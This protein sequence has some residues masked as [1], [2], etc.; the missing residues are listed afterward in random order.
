MQLV[1]QPCTLLHLEGENSENCAPLVNPNIQTRGHRWRTLATVSTPT[2]C[3][4][5]A[6]QWS[7]SQQAQ[8]LWNSDEII[9]TVNR[10]SWK[11]IWRLYMAAASK[12]MKS[13][14]DTPKPEQ[15]CLCRREHSLLRPGK[16]QC[17]LLHETCGQMLTAWNQNASKRNINSDIL[18][19]SH[20]LPSRKGYGKASTLIYPNTGTSSDESDVIGL[21]T[22]KNALLPLT[23]HAHW[24][25]DNEQPPE[26]CWPHQSNAGN[27]GNAQSVGRRLK[28]AKVDAYCKYLG[29]SVTICNQL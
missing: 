14:S 3:V 29:V 28:N 5:S 24:R 13:K 9:N 2:P 11:P 23:A 10:C 8:I 15:H 12:L 19:S 17:G 6:S 7:K 26:C 1:L 22:L 25:A 16:C 4:W 18:R 27:A 21:Q 20:S